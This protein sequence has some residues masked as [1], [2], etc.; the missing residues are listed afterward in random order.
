MEFSDSGVVKEEV[1]PK[2]NAQRS[3][4]EKVVKYGGDNDDDNEDDDDVIR[5]MDMS[6]NDQESDYMGSDSETEKK[7]KKANTKPK[8]PRKPKSAASENGSP[9]KKKVKNKN[10]YFIKINLSFDFFL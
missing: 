8:Q 2:R 10:L 6:D 3:A 7:I 9:A 4:K 5:G 1:S